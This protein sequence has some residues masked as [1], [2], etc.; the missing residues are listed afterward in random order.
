MSEKKSGGTGN[1]ERESL[2]VTLPPALVDQLKD[3]CRECRV[4]PDQVVERALVEYFREGEM[5]H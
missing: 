5:S 3:F 2:S 1:G 4:T